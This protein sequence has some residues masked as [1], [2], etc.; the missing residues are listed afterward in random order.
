MTKKLTNKQS[1][2]LDEKTLSE[3]VCAF[4]ETGSGKVWDPR[5]YRP[6]M[7]HGHHRLPK[8]RWEGSGKGRF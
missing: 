1:V 6:K 3:F 7:P 2:D 8:G 5:T 4:G